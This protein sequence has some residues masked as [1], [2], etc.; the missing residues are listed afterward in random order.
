[1]RGIQRADKDIRVRISWIE[2]IC[3][4]ETNGGTTVQHMVELDRDEK[5]LL[6]ELEEGVAG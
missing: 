1:M 4:D 6:L 5:R 3:I 2:S